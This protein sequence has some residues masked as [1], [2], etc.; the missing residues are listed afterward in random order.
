MERVDVIVIL[1]GVEFL[2]KANVKFYALIT[3]RIGLNLI[4]TLLNYIES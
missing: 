3:I 4:N 2:N 1:F